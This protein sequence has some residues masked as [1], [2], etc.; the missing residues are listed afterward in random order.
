MKKA[1][2]ALSSCALLLVINFIMTKYPGLQGIKNET[3]FVKKVTKAE[4]TGDWLV[5]HDP[6][7][8]RPGLGCIYH[9]GDGFRLN[10]S[11]INGKST[12]D[13]F[14]YTAPG[15][16]DYVN[17]RTL[18]FFDED[19]QKLTSY[20]LDTSP[21]SA[22]CLVAKKL[23]FIISNYTGESMVMTETYGPNAGKVL[24]AKRPD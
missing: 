24:Y 14:F 15:Y 18:W 9:R 4:L 11:F 17:G 5:F 1:I 20:A 6:H 7:G 12:S 13:I 21:Y 2:F 8:E 16:V 3:A 22:S 10:P 23:A 19:S